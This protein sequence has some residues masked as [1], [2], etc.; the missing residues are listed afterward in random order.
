MGYIKFTCWQHRE[1]SK[2][3]C[4]CQ[5]YWVLS[6]CKDQ[7]LNTPWT[8]FT[9]CREVVLVANYQSTMVKCLHDNIYKCVEVIMHYPIRF[10]IYSIRWNPYMTVVMISE[11][12]TWDWMIHLLG[13][14]FYCKKWRLQRPT[15]GQCVRLREQE[16]LVLNVMSS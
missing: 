6:S 9:E 10:L 11:P 1:F 3:S 16:H 14:S 2:N 5:A 15:T 12:R 4:Y 13:D 7:L 8:Y